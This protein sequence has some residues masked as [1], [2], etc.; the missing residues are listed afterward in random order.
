MS[1]S[2]LSYLRVS[3]L[4][5]RLDSG[6]ELFSAWIPFILK[7]PKHLQLKLYKQIMLGYGDICLRQ[8]ATV[9]TERCGSKTQN[10]HHKLNINTL[11]APSVVHRKCWHRGFHFFGSQS[12]EM[13][14]LASVR[15]END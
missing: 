9:Q 1:T 2:S 4:I 14:I 6:C 12:I 11:S 7:T 15:S 3:A 13:V 8:S 5:S 10:I